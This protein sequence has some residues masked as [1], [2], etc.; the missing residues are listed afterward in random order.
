MGF[1]S[2]IRFFHPV[3]PDT[4]DSPVPKAGFFSGFPYYVSGRHL[5]ERKNR[6]EASSLALIGLLSVF[7]G[8]LIGG[9]GIG[10][11]LLVPMLTFVFG[12][13]VHEAIGA[14]MFSYIFSG[15]VGAS[16]YARQGSINWTMALWLFAGAI[17][18]AFA[19]AYLSSVISSQ[20][21]EFI[22]ALLIIFAGVNAILTRGEDIKDE[23]V[24][25]RPAL[26][27]IG[28]V[29]GVGSALSGT[30]GPLVLVPVLVWLKVPVLT[31]VGLSQAVLLPIAS[32]AT[33]GN[34]LYGSVN[35]TIGITLAVSL[36][37]GATI[38]ARIAHAVTGSTLKNIV[39]WVLVVVGIFMVIRVARGWFGF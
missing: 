3:N 12:M 33:A 35:M 14:A 31:A 21:L 1:D 34:V 5:K 2:S 32:L 15:I 9:I 19:G 13:G 29:T 8:I 25:S 36:M 24:L 39:S 7:V 17:P 18:A 38:G 4:I 37:I 6:M 30:G 10:G 23:R 16:L 28:V 11:V 27:G 26:I 20:G 22:I